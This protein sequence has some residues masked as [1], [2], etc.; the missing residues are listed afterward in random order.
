MSNGDDHALDLV[1]THV[2][3]SDL[4]LSVHRREAKY[5]D[6]SPAQ[7]KTHERGWGIDPAV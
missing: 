5:T 4:W 1:G 7:S 2:A 6:Y 3:L